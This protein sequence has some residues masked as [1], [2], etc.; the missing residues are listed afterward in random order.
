MDASPDSS[1][2]SLP[3]DSWPAEW[4]ASAD[5]F[6]ALLNGPAAAPTSEVEHL[7]NRFLDLLGISADAR[8]EDTASGSKSI[9]VTPMSQDVFEAWL[10]VASTSWKGSSGGTGDCGA[11]EGTV[12]A[13]AEASAANLQAH[14]DARFGREIGPCHAQW[15]SNTLAY[16][17]VTCQ[18]EPVAAL[19]AECFAHGHHEG[20]E[21]VVY[22][23]CSGGSCDCGSPLLMNPAGFC[24]HHR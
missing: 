11:E 18:V 20:H 4:A 3:S 14:L 9:L 10:W 22:I 13:A 15:R 7:A 21:I 5:V 1:E 23:S 19:C 24:P 12:V 16:R 17:C 2:R 6:P 8:K